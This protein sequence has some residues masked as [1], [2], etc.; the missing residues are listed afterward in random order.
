MRLTCPSLAALALL[1]ATTSF[2][3][4]GLKVGTFD[5]NKLLTGSKLGQVLQ[6]DLNRYRVSKEAEIRKAGE[7]LEKRVAQYKTSVQ[8]MSPERRDEVEIELGNVRRDLERM[9]RDA[10]GELTRRR[11]KA[12]RDLETEVASILEDYGKRNGY[13]LIMQR[14]LC[15]FASESID[16]S[17]ELVRLLDARRQK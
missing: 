5:P 7:D 15:A 2:A 12:V 17:D 14:D 10:D 1:A 13:T 4:G 11:Q 8:T 16:I 9:T 3:Q 6:E